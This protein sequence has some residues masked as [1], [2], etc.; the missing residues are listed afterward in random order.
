MPIEDSLLRGMVWEIGCTQIK[1]DENRESTRVNYYEEDIGDFDQIG[2]ST[3]VVV[4]SSSCSCW[5]VNQVFS[6][7][8]DS[9]N[10][11]G[12][13]NNSSGE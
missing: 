4:C 12:C 10:F 5:D 13:R 6:V 3:M 2:F 1:E 7:S 11:E 9:C 8:G